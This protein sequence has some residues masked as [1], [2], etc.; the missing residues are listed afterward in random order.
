[1]SGLRQQTATAWQSDPPSFADYL[2]YLTCVEH[3]VLLV[4]RLGQAPSIGGLWELEPVCVEG[5]PEERWESVSS[6]MDGLLARLPEDAAVQFYLLGDPH[7]SEELATFTRHGHN[8]GV[9]GATAAD[10]VRLYEQ[11]LHTLLFEHKGIPFRCRRVRAYCSVRLWPHTPRRTGRRVSGRSAFDAWLTHAQSEFAA[12]AQVLSE[13]M[14]LAGIGLI[15]LDAHAIKAFLWRLLN[16]AEPFTATPYR[17]DWFLRDQLLGHHPSVD[18]QGITCGTQTVTVLSATEPPT[19]TRPGL[20]V[21]ERDFGGALAALLDLFPALCLVYNIHILNQ[22]QAYAGVKRQKSLAWINR[23][24]PL[25]GFSVEASVVGDDLEKVIGEVFGRGRRVL[26][27]GVHALLTGTAVELA[28]QHTRVLAAVGHLGFRLVPEETVGAA[29]VV[30]CLPLG[31]DPAADTQLCRLHRYVSANVADLLPV[32]GYFRRVGMRTGRFVWLSRR[33]ELVFFDPWTAAPSPNIFIAGVTR[34]GKSVS[35]MDLMLQGLRLGAR[36]IVLD[37]GQSYSRFCAL[38]GGTHELLRNGDQVRA[39]EQLEL[40]RAQKK[41]ADARRKRL[42]LT[43]TLAGNP[44][45]L[46]LFG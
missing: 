1:M 44:G 17:E 14:H 40:L 26:S 15:R 31:F 21:R 8:N 36:I 42:T 43:R 11:S 20:F 16:P 46:S 41:A 39:M 19:E 45:Q 7:I 35:V 3:A 29:V 23:L 5:A 37:K 38:L 27:V 6:A 10:R 25:Q 22:Q 28:S 32:Y 12:V 4:D 34:A 13:G 24:D 2:P 9:I 33:G 30:Q 18:G